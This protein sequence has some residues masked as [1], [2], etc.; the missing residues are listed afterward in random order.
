M[1]HTVY[2]GQADLSNS[3]LQNG[4]LKVVGTTPKKYGFFLLF[5]FSG[6]VMSVH[7]LFLFVS[8][9]FMPVYK[10]LV[11]KILLHTKLWT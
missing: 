4:G 9:F 2:T 3:L 10:F 8:P 7:I 11:L 5:R 1:P 6:F